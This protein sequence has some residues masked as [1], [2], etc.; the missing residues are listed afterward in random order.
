MLTAWYAS[1]SLEDNTV[2]FYS[3]ICLCHVVLLFQVGTGQ[4]AAAWIG[5]RMF[6][7]AGGEY[8]YV[9]FYVLEL[10]LI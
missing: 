1:F 3:E 6:G 9:H 5:M 4:V 10:R 8:M 7:I 2:I